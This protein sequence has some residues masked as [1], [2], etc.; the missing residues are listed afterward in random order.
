[1]TI[2]E[3]GDPIFCLFS[4]SDQQ[5]FL[6]VKSVVCSNKLHF[7]LT[8]LDWKTNNDQPIFKPD[9]IIDYNRHMGGVDLAD[10]FIKHY[11][12]DRLT[13]KWFKLSIYQ[14]SHNACV[15]Y[16]DHSRSTIS[17]LQL[18]L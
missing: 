18:G 11:H 15:V 9:R 16:K 17:T 6:T 12:R 1:M 5:F 10:Q 7:L 14:T 13:I 2:E 4:R 3:R 8:E